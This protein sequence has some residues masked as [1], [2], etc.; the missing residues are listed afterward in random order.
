MIDNTE[1]PT[2]PIVIVDDDGKPITRKEMLEWKEN[3]TKDFGNVSKALDDL[4]SR[5][6]SKDH[7]E[8]IT[9]L[10]AQLE[11]ILADQAELRKMLEKPPAEPPPPPKPPKS[12]ARKNDGEDLQDPPQSRTQR[13]NR[14]WV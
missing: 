6:T 4:K 1:K 14:G 7:G 13:S 5:P 8:A 10:S 12:R 9:K 3:L 11:R 2:E